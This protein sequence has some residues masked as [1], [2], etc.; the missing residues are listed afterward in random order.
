MLFNLAAIGWSVAMV[1]APAQ[2]DPPLAMFAVLPL[3]L[4]TFKLAKLLH[5]YQA[6]VRAGW[7]Q[8]FAAAIAGLALSH[9]IGIAV[10]KGLFTRN[11]PFFRTPKQAAKHRVRAA[12]NSA[13]EE[14]L[15]LLA[16]WLCAFGVAH[17]PQMA[18]P[19]R[20][21]W[22]I[23]LMIQSVP[24][25]AAIITSLV[26]AF[27]LPARLTGGDRAWRDTISSSA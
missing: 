26:S 5:L 21:A 6:R 2:I 19:D 25:A 4:F 9:T 10:V 8:T 1:Y 27:A 14:A 3:S 11:E 23:V 22:I 17:T 20:L 24:Y 7:R 16:L 15:I 18:S 13:R 12:L